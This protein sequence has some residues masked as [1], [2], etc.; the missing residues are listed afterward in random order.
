MLLLAFENRRIWRWQP[1][2]PTLLSC[3][4]CSV[5][6]DSKLSGLRGKWIMNWKFP[7]TSTGSFPAVSTPIF[8]IKYS[9]ERSWRDL[10]DL[11]AFVPL[12]PQYFSKLSSNFFAFFGKITD[13]NSTKIHHFEFFS[14]IFAQIFMKCCRNFAD[15]LEN[16]EIF[17]NCWIF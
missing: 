2:I 17:P 5:A 7:Q 13:L 8:A 12:R 1:L 9:L 10:Q 15:I 3:T 11:D 6:T 16:V 4:C 14:S